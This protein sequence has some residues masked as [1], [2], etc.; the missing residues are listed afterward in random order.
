MGRRY[1]YSG[2]NA[3]SPYT[4]RRR[5]SERYKYSRRLLS[6]CAGFLP[7]CDDFIET[8]FKSLRQWSLLFLLAL[9]SASVAWGVHCGRRP[10]ERSGDPGLPSDQASLDGFHSSRK[11]PFS[12][13]TINSP[14]VNHGIF[15]ASFRN[16]IHQQVSK[17][18][19]PKSS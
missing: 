12:I 10:S 7:C 19:A 8:I 15:K 16:S 17:C 5:F 4:G 11:L 13:F 14:T 3:S 6:F 18:A 9:S 1:L 2:K